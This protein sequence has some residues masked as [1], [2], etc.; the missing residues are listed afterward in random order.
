MQ[1]FFDFAIAHGTAIELAVLT[2]F[3]AL[4]GVILYLNHKGI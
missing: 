4:S 2:T 1:A 3:V